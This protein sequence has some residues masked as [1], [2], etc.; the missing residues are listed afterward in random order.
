MPLV[1]ANAAGFWGDNLDAPRRLVE[2][3]SVDYLT[4]DYLAELTMSI[5]AAKRDKNPQAG[6]ADDF[7]TVLASLLPALRAQPQLKIVT[8][9]GGMN[10]LACVRAAARL[11]ADAGLTD[12]PIGLVHGDDLLP[13]LS[14]LQL[15]GCDFAHLDTG[16]PLASQS[17]QVKSANA[18]F[19]ARPIVAALEKNARIVIS[20]RVADASLTVGPALHEFRWNWDDWNALAGA[21]AAGHLIECGAQV[22]GGLFSPWEDLDLADV[23]LPL[24]ELE[25]NGACT[26]T[27]SPTSPGIVNRH[28]VAAQLV[29]E[30]GDPRRYQTP[31][32]DVDFTSLSLVE[33]GPDRVLVRSAVGRPPSD[34]YKVSLSYAAGFTASG[35]L[36]VYGPDC[37]PKAQRCADLVRQR[38][39]LANSEPT[40]WHV[41]LLGAGD[42]IPGLHSAPADLREVMLRISVRDDRRSVVD[43]FTREL[44]PLIT[45]GPPGIA[46][47][48]TGR[49]PVRPVY[50]YWPCLVPKTL[51]PWQAE[52]RTA[53]E[54]I[55]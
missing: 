3:A 17:P 24:A 19:G 55:V 13:R 51:V 27:K 34:F 22:T 33:T 14:D 41:E 53:A 42:S 7:L 10:P 11:L 9:A 37:I 15:A 28:T 6:Y 35:Q 43:R 47:Y 20:G 44:A 1:I 8:N 4:L 25:P 46:G 29:Y 12:L 45:S 48:A 18:Y 31:D 39:A 21:T 16:Q 50:A 23:P 30:I 38:L 54:W 52:T 49:C 26:I 40:V 32:V 36:L 2:R 5:L